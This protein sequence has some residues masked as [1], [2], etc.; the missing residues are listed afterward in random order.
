M[1]LE[2]AEMR[3]VALGARNKWHPQPAR[4]GGEIQMTKLIAL[5][6]VTAVALTFSSCAQKEKSYG[7]TS[8]MSSTGSTSYAK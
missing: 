1:L 6:A 8:T 4:K 5:A 3:C 7:S 2:I